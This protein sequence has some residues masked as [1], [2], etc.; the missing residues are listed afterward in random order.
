MVLNAPQA[1]Q[2]KLVRMLATKSAIAAR[3]DACRSYMDGSQGESLKEQILARYAKISAPGQ[4]RLAKIL[5]KP[6]AKQ[7]KK[8]GGI[9]MRNRN[10][11]YEMT[12]SRKLQNKVM[13][14]PD[15]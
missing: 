10:E 2:I 13:F 4:S 8:R 12:M 7:R 11:K 3:C 6:E 9:K 5:P 14:G 15:A 1:D